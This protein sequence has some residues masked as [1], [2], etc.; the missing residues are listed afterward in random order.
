[1]LT[2]ENDIFKSSDLSLVAAISLFYPISSIDKSN[3]KKVIFIFKKDKDFD[4]VIQ[5]YWRGELKS[6]VQ[7]YFQNLKTLKNRIYDD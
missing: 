7:K 1:M 4:L 5:K 3:P 6:E 2:D